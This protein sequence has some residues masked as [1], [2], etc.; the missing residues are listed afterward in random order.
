MK[1]PTPVSKSLFRRL[2]PALLAICLAAFAS[3]DARAQD[4]PDLLA[5]E[6]AAMKAAAAQAAP[7][8][9]R[10]E[11]L[12]G[13]EKVDDLLVGIGPTSGLI[14]SADG[15]IL[16]SAFNFVQ[17]PASILATLPSGKRAAARIV[18]RDRSR[19]LVLL[20]V[21]ADEP[22][23]TPVPAPRASWRVGQWT[24]ALGRTYDGPPS[25]S[26]GVL[27]AANRVW[28][29]AVQTDAKISPSNYGGPLIDLQ[30]RV[31]GVLVPLSPTEQG[32]I[33]GAEWYD[34]GIG[35]A[36][37][38]EDVLPRLEQMKQGIDAHPGLLG[39]S[40]KGGDIYA[41]QPVI[42]AVPAK[43][44]AAKAGLQVGDTII[45]VDGQPIERQAQLK[46]ALGRR[47]AKE[48][49][50]IAVRRGDQR[51]DA[52]IELAEK[53]E[54]FAHAFLGVLPLRDGAR[55]LAG[56]GI[57]YVYPGSPAERSGVTVDDRLLAIN[58]REVTSSQQAQELLAGFEPGADVE[59]TLQRQGQSR[60]AAAVLAALPSSAPAEVPPP[61]SPDSPKDP[62]VEKP[63]TG[64]IKIK[65]PEEA[66]ECLAYVPENYDRR[67]PHGLIV[68]LRPPGEFNE[69]QFVDRWAEASSAH[70]FVL[71]APQPL[72]KA[73]WSP[74]E[75]DFIGKT[76][77][78]MVAN[79]A[80]DR[81]RVVVHGFQA[82]GAMAYL[83]AFSRRDL[84]RGAAPVD[85]ALPLRAGLPENDP[86]QRLAFFTAYA[87]GSEL[88]G[89]IEAAAARLSA[90]KFPVTLQKLPERR[91]LNDEELAALVRWADALDRL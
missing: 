63:T 33:A 80:I 51:I 12:G 55:G 16:S 87:P 74:T 56:I 64:V 19:M 27:S 14:V 85:A 24:L 40:L 78:H 72:D 67:T 5:L 79:F 52:E 77:D 49:L 62:A 46:H 43:S 66:N 25:V 53:I 69:K 86:V 84:V 32:E 44:P 73:R 42:A 48:V 83:T 3:P 47:Y 58:G 50:Q 34:S 29:K 6:E 65:L 28:G 75:V 76:I 35:F 7:C 22:L 36:I 4:S 10:I 59:L 15:Y 20:K 2:P 11:T 26:V 38:L 1:A 30:G 88:A 90:M 9:V 71:L 23:P 37:P 8:V 81:T 31:I 68:W 61:W 54:P 82:G 39:V 18:A 21:D 41:D 60:Q 91:Y 45:A 17:Q 89:P 13:R 57:R 70:R